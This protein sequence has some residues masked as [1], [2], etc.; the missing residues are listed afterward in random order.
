MRKNKNE[1]FIFDIHIKSKV[2]LSEHL[3]PFDVEQNA[4]KL[5]KLTSELMQQQIEALVRKI[6]KH[7]IDPIGLGYMPEL[8]NTNNISRWKMI[9]AKPSPKPSCALRLI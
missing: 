9:G 3:F 2:G 8:F 1:K 6:Q 4:D 7:K 5:E